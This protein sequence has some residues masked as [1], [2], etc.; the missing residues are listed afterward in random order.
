MLIVHNRDEPGV[1]GVVGR[2]LGEAGVNIDDMDVGRAPDGQAAMM[3]LATGIPVPGE[4]Q[5]RLR[6]EP[7]VDTV[8]AVELGTPGG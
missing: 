7:L 6:S 2:V 1:I 8:H 4:V 5:E 3:V